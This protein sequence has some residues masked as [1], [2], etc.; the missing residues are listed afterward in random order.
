MTY[1]A[2]VNDMLFMMRHVGGLDRTLREGSYPDL[3]LDV[4]HDILGE[5]GRFAGEVLAPINRTG[6][7]HGAELR[8]GAITTAPGRPTRPGSPVVGARSPVRSNTAARICP[9]SSMPAASR[10]GTGRAWHSASLLC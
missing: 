7:R 3:S 8:D 5:A 10:C 2:P 1:R 4:I 6:D 9:S